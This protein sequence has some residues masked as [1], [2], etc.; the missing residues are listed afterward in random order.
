MAL[1]AMVVKQK[2]HSF[3]VGSEAGA[4]FFLLFSSCTSRKIIRP[5]IRKSIIAWMKEPYP[6]LA[7]PA[8]IA[9]QAKSSP[10]MIYPIKA[11]RASPTSEETILPN[12]VPMITATAKSVKFPCTMDFIYNPFAWGYLDK[13]G[14]RTDQ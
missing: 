12:A 7:L 6:I 5:M 1:I 10:P 2:E 11:I 13:A 3:A 4:G 14:Q 9:R 8:V